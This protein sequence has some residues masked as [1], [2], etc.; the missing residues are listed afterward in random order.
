[1]TAILTMEMVVPLAVQLRQISSAE[2]NFSLQSVIS[3]ETK[4]STTGK[5]VMTEVSVM[6]T[7]VL[8]TARLKLAIPVIIPN[9]QYVLLKGLL[10]AGMKTLSS[11]EK[12]ATT[13]TR[14]M[15][16]GAAALANSKI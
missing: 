16:M 5:S 15:E 13:G 3:A 7:V 9:H 1:M 11:W 12:N 4:S 6:A 14:S 2:P 8:S 10:C